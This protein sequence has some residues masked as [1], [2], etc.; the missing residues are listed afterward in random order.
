MTDATFQDGAEAPLHLKAMDADDLAVISALIQDAVFPA[1]EMVYQRGQRRFAVLLNRFRWEDVTAAERAGRVFE[2][3]QAV[4]SF[5]D[6]LGVSTQGLRRGDFETVLSVLSV[7]F[8]P[9]VDGT[10][11]VVVM[12]A[13][14]AAIA[15]EVECLDVTLLDVTRPYG[16]PSGKM[17]GHPA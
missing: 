16:A 7:G 3:V 9:G 2:R 8:E 10:G 11:R 14:E 6:V 15:L 4:L 12:L 17:P 1:G 5:D 13:G